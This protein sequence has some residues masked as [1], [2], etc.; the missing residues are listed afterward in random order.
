MIDPD[1]DTMLRYSNGGTHN[2]VM[3]FVMP[4][5][6]IISIPPLAGPWLWALV[7]S[8]AHSLV[9]T[10]WMFASPALKATLLLLAANIRSNW[11]LYEKNCKKKPV[12][13]F[14][15]CL[16]ITDLFSWFLS[17]NIWI[18]EKNVLIERVGK[19][20]IYIFFIVRKRIFFFF[21]ATSSKWIFK[22]NYRIIF[23]S[24]LE[25]IL[26]QVLSK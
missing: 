1:T 21:T 13:F 19:S 5:I 3:M 20:Y 11:F 15:P 26:S 6:F 12:A 16:V 7:G 17:H 8:T 10:E 25:P 23:M 18:C 9:L 22:K 2:D 4:P 14:L 24:I